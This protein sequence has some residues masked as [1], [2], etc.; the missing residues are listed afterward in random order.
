[1]PVSTPL[2][3]VVDSVLRSRPAWSAWELAISSKPHWIAARILEA[4]YEAGCG[5]DMVAAPLPWSLAPVDLRP[6]LSAAAA[7]RAAHCARVLGAEQR[8]A[9]ATKRAEAQRPRAE[10]GA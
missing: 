2:V 10:V 8:R 7:A 9:P 1:M 4:S 3:A 6:T 5:S